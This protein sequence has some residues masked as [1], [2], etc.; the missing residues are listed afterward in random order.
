MVKVS[1]PV[2]G[3]T[4]ETEDAPSEIIIQLLNL[5]APQHASTQITASKGPKLMRPT[6]DMGVE[7]ETWNTFL[8]RWETFRVSSGI[9]EDAAP[10]QL[11]QCTNGALGDLLLKA[12]PRLITNNTAD[13]LKAMK[14]LAVI[15]VAALWSNG[16]LLNSY[17]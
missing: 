3:C 2:S 10:T 9:G 13:V 16:R 15:P 1:C 8:R 14:Q 6:I 7:E 17:P 5:H 11:F 4:Y 12:D